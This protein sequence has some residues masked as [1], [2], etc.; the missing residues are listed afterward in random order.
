M[1]LFFVVLTFCS[2]EN[3]SSLISSPSQCTK[4][5]ISPKHLQSLRAEAE[6]S[7]TPSDSTTTTTT[8]NDLEGKTIY[9]RTF[10]RLTP[11][12]QVTR[13]NALMLEERLRFELDPAQP[14]YIL[15]VGPRSFIFRKGTSEDEITGA[16]YQ[17]DVPGG[18]HNGP[19]TMDASIATALWMASNPH[20][21]Q[22]DLIELGCGSG[23]ASI[24]GCIGA[25]LVL[26]ESI[27]KDTKDELLKVPKHKGAFP[28]RLSHLTLSDEGEEALKDAL[29]MAKQFD[30]KQIT[31]K[32]LRWGSRLLPGRRYERSYR[33]ILGSD[34]DFS[35]PGSKDLARNVAN[36]LSPSNELAIASIKEGATSN[37]FF[38]GLGMDMDEPTSS[39]SSSAE[40]DTKILPTFAHVAPDTNENLRFLKQ[41]LE[42]GFKMTVDSGYISLERLN[43]APQSL[44]KGVEEAE[45]EKL[46]TLELKD[47]LTRGYQFV[48]AVHHPDYSGQGTGEYFFPLETGEY[49]GGSRSTWLEPEEG[50]SPW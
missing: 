47:D 50:G 11:A 31:L 7:A 48:Q 23:T 13:P 49:E 46:D 20:L 9:Q 15:P 36:Y 27:S 18:K 12:S 41:F 17:F 8:T 39:T 42:K 37:A 14:G 4:H 45:L 2:I 40:L 26:G 30:S 44:E 10:Y 1:R 33:T 19:G 21:I 35:Y 16:L 29:E 43:F 22:G 38:R 34:L 6:D 24:L 25:K 28:E 5:I 32:D 3:A